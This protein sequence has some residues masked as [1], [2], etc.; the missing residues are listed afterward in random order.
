MSQLSPEQMRAIDPKKSFWVEASAGSGKTKVLIDR[1]IRLLLEGA[2][3]EHI[4][5]LTFTNAAA[6]E[7]RNRIYAK[8][9]RWCTLNEEDLGQELH[10]LGI[11]SPSPLQ[12]EKA[13]ALFFSLLEKPTELRIQTIHGFSQFLLRTFPLE[14]GLAPHFKVL[15]EKA[16]HALRNQAFHKA[17]QTCSEPILSLLS[18]YTS[19]KG[20]KNLVEARLASRPSVSLYNQENSL[21]S[22][23][24]M[25]ARALQSYLGIDPSL[26]PK[27]LRELFLSSLP[28]LPAAPEEGL[29]PTAKDE[30][31]YAALKAAAGLRLEAPDKALK[32]YK[33][34]FL[35]KKSEPRQKIFSKKMEEEES[36]REWVK[37]SQCAL[38]E[39][40]TSLKHYSVLEAS[41]ALEELSSLFLSCYTESKKEDDA[42]DYDDLIFYATKLLK[43][44]QARPWIL[45][46]LEHDITHLLVD[47]AQDTNPN[48]WE[49]VRSLV[50]NFFPELGANSYLK[51]LF[52]VGDLKQSIYSFQGADPESF[53]KIKNILGSLAKQENLS[54][55]TSYRSAPAILTFADHLLNA[56]KD[57]ENSDCAGPYLHRPFRAKDVGY[58]ELWPLVESP[59]KRKKEDW[60]MPQDYGDV[61]ESRLIFAHHISDQIEEWLSCGRFL[62]SRNRS[63]EPRDIM[64]LVR[65]RDSFVDEL[66]R[67]LKRKG[68]PVAGLDRLS[69][70]DHI[71]IQ[72]LL[73]LL[74]FVLLPVD[75]LNLAILLKGPLF[76][77][78]EDDLFFLCSSAGDACL[79]QKIASCPPFAAVSRKLENY[80]QSSK[81]FFE[82]YGFFLN[83]LCQ[84]QG[85]QRFIS[86]LGAEVY[87]VLE[88]FLNLC[89]DYREE[90]PACLQLFA[91]WIKSQA[92]EVKRP[93]ASSE[94]NVVRI[95]TIHGA[96]GLEAPIVILPDT[97]QVPKGFSPLYKSS[98]S[99]PL[100][101]WLPEASMVTPLLSSLKSYH[102]DQEE[103]YRLL[104]VAVT[105]AEDELYIGGWSSKT[106]QKFPPWYQL[107]VES[108]QTLG[109]SQSSQRWGEIYTY[110]SHG[111]PS[112]PYPNP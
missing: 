76:E 41:S 68:I 6:V 36:L 51:T 111:A 105:R 24:E 109:V 107:C 50:C 86:H 100:M 104:Y 88:E 91:E 34:L 54:F 83:A 62:P 72:D 43:N 74:N 101:I 9:S 58:V 42:L 77:M 16:A 47:E 87:E 22:S 4:L 5:C 32:A 18:R 20:L 39:L 55:T 46:K 1:V 97:A 95:L 49:L 81:E 85:W 99:H 65:R 17:L 11:E 19:P 56:L 33:S 90:G 67:L 110:G 57:P 112:K 30:E 29:F 102:K 12:R 14:V 106:L 93:N 8:L 78:A 37:S 23:K 38:L 70:L 84:D 64:I 45:F 98:S 103:Y 31:I 52:V 44:G 10:A 73:S 60:E 79:F 66:A 96:K 27:A 53:G 13:G 21:E 61:Q 71:A 89:K 28:P 25:Y 94:E 59:L 82:P 40:Q 80:L 75:D 7:M 108:M 35:T 48:Q 2:A 15:T 69:L 92:I 3:P 63:I 26:T